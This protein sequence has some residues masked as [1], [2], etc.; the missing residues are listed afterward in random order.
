MVRPRNVGRYVAEK[1]TPNWEQEEFNSK[2]E[3]RKAAQDVTDF[4]E[5]IGKL[6]EK[7]IISFNLPTEL[8]DAFMLLKKMGK[9]P[10]LKRQ[11]AFIGKYFRKDEELIIRVKE[12][13]LEIESKEKQKNAHFHRLEKWRDRMLVEGDGALNEFLE[14]YPQADRSQLRQWIRNANKEAEQNKPAKSAKALFQYL[15][16]LE[17]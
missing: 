1:E 14:N 9:G 13:F 5:S 10:A 6:T 8:F 12:R 4:G 7:Q 3:I 2:T 16:S 17:W 11:K 15:K